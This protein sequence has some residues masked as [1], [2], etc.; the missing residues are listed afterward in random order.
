VVNSHTLYRLSYQGINCYFRLVFLRH[1]K[2]LIAVW[3]YLIFY[4]GIVSINRPQG[5][6]P[7]ALPLRHPDKAFF[8]QAPNKK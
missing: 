7:C 5:Y 6:E 8:L 1:K 2:D 4:R 3:K